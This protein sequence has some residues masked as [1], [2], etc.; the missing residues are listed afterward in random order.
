MS[1][2]T[3]GEKFKEALALRVVQVTLCGTVIA[4]TIIAVVSLCCGRYLRNY[5]AAQSTVPSLKEHRVL[6]GRED[7]YTNKSEMG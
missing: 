2:V 5:Q 6:G 7:V 3:K 1:R 4:I